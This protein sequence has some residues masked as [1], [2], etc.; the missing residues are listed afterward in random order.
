MHTVIPVLLHVPQCS[1]DNFLSDAPTEKTSEAD[2]Y[3]G[4]RIQTFMIYLND[5]EAGGHTIFP[6]AGISIK[7]RFRL[8]WK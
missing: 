5:V 2:K 1:F 8:K 6:Q 4:Y 3:G 7:P